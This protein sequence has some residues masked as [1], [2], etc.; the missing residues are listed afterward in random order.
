MAGLV[1][2]SVQPA[3]SLPIP[4]SLRFFEGV[5]EYQNVLVNVDILHRRRDG[6]FRLIEVK[7]STDVK[8][9]HLDDVGIQYRV[10]S[11]SGLDLASA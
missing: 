7:S 3:T 4:K 8:E 6:R 2:R 5:F 11:R 1:R 10:V 9:E